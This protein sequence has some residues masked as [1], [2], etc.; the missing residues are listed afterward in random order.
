M[1]NNSLMVVIDMM[2][3]ELFGVSRASQNT[4][5]AYKRDLKQFS[6]FCS[7]NNLTSIKQITEKHIRFFVM[8]MNQLELDRKSISRHLSSLRRLFNFALRNELIENNPM[9]KISNPKSKR[10]LPETISL[11]SFLEIYR[12]I[13]E[14]N[15]LLV[16]NRNKAIFELLYG[17]ALRVSELCGLNIGD[18][19]LIKMHVRVLGKGSKERIIPL[20][21]KS[22]DVIKEYFETL[23]C[24]HFNEPIFLS[25]NN[26]RISRFAVYKIV[27]KYLSK[28]TDIKK[29]SPHILRH[30]AATHM[31]DN[32][33]DIMAVKEILGHENLSTTQ[34]YTHISV[35]R[36]KNSYKRAH[37][38]S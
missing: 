19:D 25:K 1:K 17:C 20:G 16:I 35:E 7:D 28:V 14:E 27:N 37:P 10:K 11:D 29:K 33:A 38:K 15:D 9:N 22:F 12:F 5:D 24:R 8:T 36:L 30:A 2:L 23:S 18:V 6:I 31:L 26:K 3:T 4:I 21:S 13:E 34:I 32:Q